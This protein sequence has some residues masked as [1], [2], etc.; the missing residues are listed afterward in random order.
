MD[1]RA[2]L[3]LAEGIVDCETLT[4]IDV[5]ENIN[6]REATAILGKVGT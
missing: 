5:R 4:K 3:V 6:S 1:D 2:A